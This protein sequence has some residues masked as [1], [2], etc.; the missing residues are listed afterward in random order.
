MPNIFSGIIWIFWGE[1]ST[2]SC[3]VW[4]VVDRT[5]NIWYKAQTRPSIRNKRRSKDPL[6]TAI[7]T[8]YRTK[9]V[10]HYMFYLP[11][12]IHTYIPQIQKHTVLKLP[13]IQKKQGW[14]TRIG[15]EQWC[16]SRSEANRSLEYKLAATNCD[17]G[18]LFCSLLH[19][20]AMCSGQAIHN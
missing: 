15:S 11:K 12:N 17:M 19:R 2:L 7:A 4:A 9:S 13:Q 20:D 16:W 8:C 6:G 10:T 3:A 5:K 18:I 1:A 14:E